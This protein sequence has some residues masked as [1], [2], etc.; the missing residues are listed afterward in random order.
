MVVLMVV[1]G[2]D[3]DDDDDDEENGIKVFILRCLGRKFNRDHL[4]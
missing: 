2:G 1:V 4:L 3:D